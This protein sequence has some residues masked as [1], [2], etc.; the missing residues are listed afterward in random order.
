MI[1]MLSYRGVLNEVLLPE[2]RP[3]PNVLMYGIDVC[4]HKRI[5]NSAK[6]LAEEFG[7][8]R[9]FSTPLAED[10]MTDLGLGAQ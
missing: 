3:D 2:M 7:P 1:R 10:A 6:A 5:L 8:T 4:G 9:C